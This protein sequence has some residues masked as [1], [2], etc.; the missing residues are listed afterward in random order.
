MIQIGRY[1]FGFAVASS[2]V[3]F[4]ALSTC[5]IVTAISQARPEWP[6]SLTGIIVVN[7]SMALLVTLIYGI[8]AHFIVA[9][10][11]KRKHE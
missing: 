5:A 1:K 10:I 11:N 9:L 4:I 8:F 7:E 2:I 6:M 3:V